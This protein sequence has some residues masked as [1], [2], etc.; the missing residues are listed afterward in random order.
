M[1]TETQLATEAIGFPPSTPTEEQI[2]GKL[3]TANVSGTYAIDLNAAS[4]FHL[5]MTA[6]TAFTFINV[7]TTII[8]LRR[9][10]IRLTGAFSGTFTQAG[11]NTF[12]DDYEATKWNDVLVELWFTTVLKGLLIFQQRETV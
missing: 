11:L 2:K 1:K 5:T 12:G 4:D 10:K 7:P 3:I 8:E 6:N 9:C